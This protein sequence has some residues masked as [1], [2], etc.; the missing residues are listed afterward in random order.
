MVEERLLEL[1]VP[2]RVLEI[3]N[4]MEKAERP[5][6]KP[7][8]KPKLPPFLGS[9]LFFAFFCLLFLIQG[10]VAAAAVSMPRL[11]PIPTC[12][13]LPLPSSKGALP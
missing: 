3:A 8:R 5:R 12:F 11:P 6:L 9:W 13:S 2:K 1:G 4:C 10:L 7:Y